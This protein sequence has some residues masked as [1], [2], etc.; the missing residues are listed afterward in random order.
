MKL[1]QLNKIRIDGEKWSRIVTL[2]CFMHCLTKTSSL[3]FRHCIHS[4]WSALSCHFLCASLHDTVPVNQL[5]QVII[6]LCIFISRKLSYFFCPNCLC[7]LF[8]I[9]ELVIFSKQTTKKELKH[10]LVREMIAV[11]IFL[12]LCF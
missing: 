1:G 8:E 6:I 12:Y 10:I 9:D 3:F 11:K 5:L 2:Q 4:Y 7:L